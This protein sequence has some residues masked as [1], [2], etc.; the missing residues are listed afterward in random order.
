M[1]K[2]RPVSK[3]LRNKRHK[4]AN[5]SAEKRRQNPFSSISLP[6][7]FGHPGIRFAAPIGYAGIDVITSYGQW[8]PPFDREK[9][10]RLVTERMADGTLHWFHKSAAE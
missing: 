3:R 2:F 4:Q 1:S 5:Q 8:L 10:E 7:L 9:S 6:I